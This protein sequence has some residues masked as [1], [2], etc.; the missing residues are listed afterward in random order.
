MNTNININAKF[1]FKRIFGRCIAPRITPVLPNFNKG[2]C[3]CEQ[4]ELDF[5]SSSEPNL[6]HFIE[7]KRK[8]VKA[9]DQGGLFDLNLSI[10]CLLSDS[11]F[12]EKSNAHRSNKI[13]VLNKYS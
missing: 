12:Y 8:A 1:I 5:S 10:N 2:E 11:S 6:E 13:A 4:L 9:T 3:K 7:F